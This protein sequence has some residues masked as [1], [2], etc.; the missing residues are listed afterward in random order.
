MSTT[1]WN[2]LCWNLR[3][4]ND[5]NKCLA[6]RNKIDESNCSIVCLQETKKESFDHSF[7]RKCCPRRFDK[8]EFVPSVGASGGLIVIWCSSQFTGTVIHN[9]SFVLTIKFEALQCN[10]TWFLSNIYGPCA[11][12]ERLDFC[13]LAFSAIN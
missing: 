12:Q 3:G 6:L 10:K 11:G 4:M 9:M 5:D 13:R 1:L 7:L 8:F 2:I